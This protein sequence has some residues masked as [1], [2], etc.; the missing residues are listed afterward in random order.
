MAFW[1]RKNTRVLNVGD[2]VNV[3]HSGVF[4]QETIVWTIG[5]DIDLDVAQDLFDHKRDCLYA[6]THLDKGQPV[7][8][9]L[10]RKGWDLLQS[11]LK[12]I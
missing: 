8:T 11:R 12:A 3:V 1:N 10:S 5:E 2:V 7:V 6:M 9:A 4:S